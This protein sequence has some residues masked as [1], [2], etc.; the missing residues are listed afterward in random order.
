MAACQMSLMT[1]LLEKLLIWNDPRGETALVVQ[2]PA[3]WLVIAT[4]SIRGQSHKEAF[5]SYSDVI[6][7]SCRDL[8]RWSCVCAPL[9]S[10][11]STLSALQSVNNPFDCHRP[12]VMRLWQ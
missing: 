5:Q 3:C 8:G 11:Q 1:Q 4:V 6:S 2:Y 7:P 12:A 9:C 10:C